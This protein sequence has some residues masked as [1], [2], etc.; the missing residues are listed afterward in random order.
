MTELN[1]CLTVRVKYLG[2]IYLGTQSDGSTLQLL[3]NR[4]TARSPLSPVDKF[5]NKKYIQCRKKKGILMEM[6][7][8]VT[9][10][11]LIG[12]SYEYRTGF[13]MPG[14]NIAIL[15]D[16]TKICVEEEKS[17]GITGLLDYIDKDVKRDIDTSVFRKRI[18]RWVKTGRLPEE[19]EV[20]G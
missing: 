17:E 15:S 11:Q 7:L 8:R 1:D 3:K 14:T 2:P 18:D 12:H 16:G 13:R 5:R 9:G 4:E 20:M 6:P 10:V 19:K